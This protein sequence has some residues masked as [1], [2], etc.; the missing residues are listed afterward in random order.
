MSSWHVV[1]RHDDVHH[2]KRDEPLTA[3]PFSISRRW[4]YLHSPISPRIRVQ[5]TGGS[6]SLELVGGRARLWVVWDGGEA[7]KLET[8]DQLNHG[9][10]TTLTV[11]LGR[12]NGVKQGE[13]GGG[14]DDPRDCLVGERTE[15]RQE[16]GG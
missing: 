12:N 9:N 5:R 11:I 15:A 6:I 14:R 3:A 1:K 10:W 8:K 4:Y 2:A 7:W 13:E 16:E